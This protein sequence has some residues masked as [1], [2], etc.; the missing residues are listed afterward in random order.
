MITCIQAPI[1]DPST[2]DEPDFYVVEVSIQ[3][4]SHPITRNVP[5]STD[6][7]MISFNDLMKGIPYTGPGLLHTMI[8]VLAPSLTFSWL[9]QGLIV[10]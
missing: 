6:P 4:G 10:S 8:E 5:A 3:D 9:K 7:L 1:F 2:I